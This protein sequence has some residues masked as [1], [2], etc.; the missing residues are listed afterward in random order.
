M[1]IRV[2]ATSDPIHT[3]QITI[4]LVEYIEVEMGLADFM[5]MSYT[6]RLRVHLCD[7][8]GILCDVKSIAIDQCHRRHRLS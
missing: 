4:F 2:F 8:N 3:L 7:I 5:L 1:E 6:I